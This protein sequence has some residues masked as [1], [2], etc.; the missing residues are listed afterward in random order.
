MA[1]R[2]YNS[3]HGRRKTGR[4]IL[5][6]ALVLVLLAA[7]AFLILQDWIVY[8]SDGSI[9]LALPFLRGEDSPQA[10][11]DGGGD[12]PPV[13][14][15]PEGG[16]DD[17]AEEPLRARVLTAQALCAGGATDLSREGYNAFLTEVKGFN[18]TYAYLSQQATSQAVAD[19]AVSQSQLAEAVE[20]AGGL[21]AIALVG[22]FH[23]SFHAFADMAGA[24]I[25]QQGGYI[26]YDNLSSHWM[27]PAKEGTRTYMAA[28]LRECADMGFDEVV[29][30]DFGYPTLGNL[31]NIDYSGLTVTK[32]E[33]L[34]GFLEEM[35]RQAGDALSLSLSLTE[36]QVLRGTDETSGLDLEAFLPL[37]DRLYISDVTDAGAVRAAAAAAGG[38]EEKLVLSMAGEGENSSF[39]Q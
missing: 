20:A 12:S 8:Q 6:A 26:W 35:R 2:G 1:V 31:G 9:T 24:G 25:C 22:C 18:G 34:C 32:T 30:T 16:A 33:A 13:E 28:V 29:L 21:R 11:E 7:A 4:V 36:D 23:D 27:D 39:V 14:I 15:L 3:Y 19:G 5:I 10:G 38:Q 17:K 37:V